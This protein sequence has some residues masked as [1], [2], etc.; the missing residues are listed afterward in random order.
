MNDLPPS[1]QPPT[2]DDTPARDTS[3]SR[4][5]LS[6]VG[7]EQTSA[8]QAPNSHRW[9]IVFGGLLALRMAQ[10]PQRRS[11]AVSSAR[12]CGWLV[13]DGFQTLLVLMLLPAGQ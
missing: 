4:I 13:C 7:L 12:L 11:L 3:V 5:H 9:R 1:Q 2:S 10:G 6:S 8:T